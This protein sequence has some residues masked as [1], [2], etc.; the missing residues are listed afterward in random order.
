[1]LRALCSVTINMLQ[2]RLQNRVTKYSY[3]AYHNAWFLV[4]KTTLGYCLINAVIKLN[5]VTLR[6]CNL[7]LIANKFAEDFAGIVVTSMINLFSQYNQILL[8]EKS[9]DYTSFYT[10]LGLL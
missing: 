6:D 1:M 8:D 10:P 4:K 2:E 7:P 3:R 9:R 5:I